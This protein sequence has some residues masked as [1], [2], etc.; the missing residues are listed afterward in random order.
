MQSH[1]DDALLRY[2]FAR[3]KLTA[4]DREVQTAKL[5]SHV[6]SALPL[7]G[8]QHQLL[9][10]LLHE[11]AELSDTFSQA[12]RLLADALADTKPADATTTSAEKARQ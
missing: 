7:S 11:Q 3:D 2:D 5:R 9:V 4:I 1:P 6:N 12:A 10:A 8:E